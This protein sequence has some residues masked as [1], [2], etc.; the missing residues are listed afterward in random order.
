MF[1]KDTWLH[2]Q[3]ISFPDYFFFGFVP[4]CVERIEEQRM[5]EKEKEDNQ[6]TWWFLRVTENSKDMKHYRKKARDNAKH[7]DRMKTFA[8]PNFDADIFEEIT[9]LH[10]HNYWQEKYKFVWNDGIEREF[11]TK[12]DLVF[13]VNNLS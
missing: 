12:R 2:M 1:N 10:V 9:G 13:Y 11:E 6:T 5:T 7:A 4:T 3:S 8:L